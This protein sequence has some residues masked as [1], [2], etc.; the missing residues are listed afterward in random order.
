MHI[1]SNLQKQIATNNNKVINKQISVIIW[2][3]YG[4]QITSIL[5]TFNL[6]LTAGH[7]A[8][9]GKPAYVSVLLISI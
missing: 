4:R 6:P 2:R 1:R 9:S 3:L 7:T 8:F 5:L